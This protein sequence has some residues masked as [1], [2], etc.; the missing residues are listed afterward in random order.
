MSQPVEPTSQTVEWH[1]HGRDPEITRLAASVKRRAQWTLPDVISE[2][3]QLLPEMVEV[4]TLF[5]QR[6]AHRARAAARAAAGDVERVVTGSRITRTDA[7]HA[8]AGGPADLDETRAS[9]VHAERLATARRVW[10]AAERVRTSTETHRLDVD[11]LR[12]VAVDAVHHLNVVFHRHHRFAGRFTFD[13][14][15][16][17]EVADSFYEIGLQRVN[18]AIHTQPAQPHTDE[19][20]VA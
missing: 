7:F 19:E 16:T 8:P 6:I 5:R 18:D 20:G 9:R 15:T 13:L 2:P 10:E 4:A 17:L 3:D 11:A 1:A 12:A 14:P